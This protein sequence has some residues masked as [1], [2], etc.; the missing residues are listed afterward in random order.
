[1]PIHVVRPGDG[2]MTGGGPIRARVIEDGSHTAH[3]L[4][5][6]ECTVQ[7]GPAPPPQHIHREHDEVFIVTAG[8]PRFVSDT[9][10]VGVEA[11]GARVGPGR[12]PPTFSKP[13]EAP[14]TIFG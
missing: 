2:E 4:S 8:K 6:V 3:R 14:A 9:T 12:T 11:G 10:S 7:A 5:I 1:M 13:L